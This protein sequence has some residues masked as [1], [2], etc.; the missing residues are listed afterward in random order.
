MF[1]KL[2]GDI[3]TEDAYVCVGRDGNS[4][5]RFRHLRSYKMRGPLHTS[6]FRRVS[7][8]AP[9]NQTEII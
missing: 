6:S 4:E 7:M 3:D 8:T 5:P 2:P 1:K 9:G